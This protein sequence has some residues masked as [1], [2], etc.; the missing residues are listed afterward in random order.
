MGDLADRLP[1]CQRAWGLRGGERLAGGFR[2]E[3]LA[4]TT[5]PGD[6]V[7]LKLTATP[8]E[9]RAEAAAL[10]AWSGTGA[11]VRLI[12]A[13][14]GR[15]AL[16]LER[17]RPGTPLP[18]RADPMAVP[19]AAD[20]LS[21][22]H[23]ISPGT[24]AFPAL[25]EV[26]RRMED[27]S[28]LDARY[29]QQASNDPERGVAGLRR[30]GA[31]RAAALDLCASTDQP[32]LL[33]GDFLDKNLLHA[34]HGYLAIDPIP[35]LGDPCSDAGFFAAGHPP[36]DAILERAGAIAARMGL[37]Q[38]R[39]RRW[40]AVWTVLD[41]CSAWRVDQSDLEALLLGDEFERVLAGGS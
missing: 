28:R 26:Y 37:N 3:V 29:E 36:A 15:G 5:G 22:L 35:S 4:C 25:G 8:R 6:E 9:T 34:G 33:H 27:Q 2:S 11:A 40:A 19:V 24:F 31:A 38:Q 41:A 30:L 18:G 12:A 1:A 16:L 10:S 39:A 20:L 21:R 14:L 32:V 13:D 23:R 17:I 7:I